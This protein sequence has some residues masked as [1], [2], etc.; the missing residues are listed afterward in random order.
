MAV[1]LDT[2]IGE[3]VIDLYINDCP[4]ASKNFLKLCKCKY[5]NGCLFWNVQPNFIAQTGDPTGTGNGGNSSFGIASGKSNM[6]FASEIRKHLKHN[7][8]GLVSMAAAKED[9]NRSQFFFTL[10]DYDLDHLDGKHTIF[11]EVAEG[12]DVLEKLNSVYIDEDGRPF[13]DIRIRHTYILDDPFPDL[14]GMESKIPPQSP[15]HVVTEEDPYAQYI[16]PEETVSRRIPYEMPIDMDDSVINEANAALEER[17]KAKEAHSRA[18]VLEMTGDIPDADIKPPEN[19]LF[20]CRLNPV[21]TDADLELIFSR[22]GKIMSCEVIRDAV[23]GDSL[24]YAF[25][26][27]ETED[28]C[29]EAYEK[30]NNV[31]VGRYQNSV[32]RCCDYSM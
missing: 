3:L 24:S 17:I 19:V 32:G 7:K 18:I 16:P 11:G 4:N 6:P 15:V 26:E 28:S 21:T 23:T 10:R 2:S 8:M 1:L 13:Q 9:S 5:F 27:F 22:F 25:I 14:P 12:L 30:M 20:V 31:L 29:V